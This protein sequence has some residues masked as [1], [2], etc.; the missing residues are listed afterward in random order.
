MSDTS[1]R[2]APDQYSIVQ[3][4]EIHV[5]TERSIFKEELL[6]SYDETNRVDDR[7]RKLLGHRS[8]TL[9]IELL[10]CLHRPPSPL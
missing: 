7:S 5:V 8:R 3:A 1:T 6:R 2:T 10:S 9:S 4:W